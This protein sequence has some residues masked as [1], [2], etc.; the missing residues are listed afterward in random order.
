MRA[1]GFPL[2]VLIAAAV[3]LPFSVSFGQASLALAQSPP[4]SQLGDV[5]AAASKTLEQMARARFSNLT[6]A[7]LTLVRMAPYRNLAWSGPSDD[8]DN[9]TN[10]P[11]HGSAWGTD[12]SIRAPIIVW[13]MTDHSAA[14]M[15]DPSGIGI[16]GALIRGNLDLTYHDATLPLTMLSCAIPDGVDFSFAH[17]QE[18]DLRRSWTGPI[19]GEQAV[20]G[21]DITL[22]LGAYDEVDLY[23]AEIGGTVDLTG[24]YLI[25]ANPFS[26]VEA[27]IHGD[28][29]FHEGFNTAGMI[30][31]RL[32]H[33][34]QGLSFN[35]AIFT[36]TGI[37]GLN[38]ERAMIDGALY[39]V[40]ITVGPHTQ[41]DLGDAHAASLWDDESSWP[42]RGNLTITGFIYGDFSGGPTDGSLR[43][44]WLHRQPMDLWSQPQPYRQLAQVLSQDGE[45]EGAIKVRIA[46]ENAMTQFGHLTAADRLWRGIL[47][48]T[49]GYGYRPLRALWWILGFV[50]LGAALFSWGYRARLI[51]PTEEH[52]YMTFVSTGQPPVHYPA[53]SGFI[54]SLEN[55]MPVVDLHQGIYWRPNPSHARLGAEIDSGEPNPKDGLTARRAA[56][57]T[58]LRWYL[59][60]HI[61]AGWAITPLLFAGL[62][63]LL[64]ND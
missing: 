5:L 13:L 49:I 60:M 11:A 40:A 58:M 64:R 14:S 15:V 4:A 31:M 8:P 54:Y 55:F 57:A 27:T 50:T 41:L 53:F 22:R 37:N 28:V 19:S 52:A 63:G 17:V 34:G 3:I 51:T 46:K 6:A 25:G 45:E 26:A 56:A 42:A 23:R 32:A 9:P 39:W 18:I 24:A 33:I 7:E 21:G 12:R 61:L 30:D 62:S 48:I 2:A 35:H 44:D 1:R 20:V 59:W 43:L 10:N 29:L 38:A 16:A 36:G 47:R